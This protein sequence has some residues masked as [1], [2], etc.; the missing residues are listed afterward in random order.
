MAKQ[1]EGTKPI[2]RN[3]KARFQYTV[4]ET[5][6]AGIALRGTEVKSL[7]DGKVSLA[8]GFARVTSGEL[9]LY[10]AHIDIYKAGSYAT[11]CGRGSSSCTGARSG[12]SRAR[13]PRKA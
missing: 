8:E 1:T 2:A 9:V 6:E 12:V 10:G 4:I 11:R 7:R 5:F 3:K 13:P